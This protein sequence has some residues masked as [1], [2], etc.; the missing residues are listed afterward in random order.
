MP[1]Y[2][3]VTGKTLPFAVTTGASPSNRDTAAPSSVADMT[4][5]LS[6]GATFSRASSASA[7]PRSACRLLSWYSSN[8][9]A[10][11]PSSAGS[12]CSI[13]VS[14]PSV[15]TSIRVSRDT[16]VSSRIRYPTVRPTPS[17]SVSAMRIAT[18][19]AASRRGSSIK[20]RLLAAQGSCSSTS[21][22][23]VLFPAPGG[24]VS[25]TEEHSRSACRNSGSAS[26]IGSPE[27]SRERITKW[28][29]ARSSP[30]GW[31]RASLYSVILANVAIQGIRALTTAELH[32]A[33]FHYAE[34]DL[35]TLT[36]SWHELAAIGQS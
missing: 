23:T 15:T 34:S 32:K 10:A 12:D 4:T 17:P 33:A 14:T 19:R 18:A 5:I 3:V 26:S 16:R 1:A 11:T 20:M 35:K 22:T 24:A 13:R 36:K 30:P 31:R 9:T 29:L 6:S 7:S 28:P 2:R 25:A 21:G 27:C 8:K